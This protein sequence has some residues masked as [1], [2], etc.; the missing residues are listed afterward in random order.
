M[1]KRV[2]TKLKKKGI[3]LTILFAVF[4]TFVDQISKFLILIYVKDSPINII[5]DIFTF[6]YSENTGIA[7]SIPMPQVLLIIMNILLIFII[8]L[9]AIIDFRI[10][11]IH[12][13]IVIAA[14]I[15]G[16]MGNMV[17]RFQYGYVIDFISIWKYPIFNLADVFITVGILSLVVFYGKIKRSKI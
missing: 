9:L 10:E 4:F 17:D 3:L 8:V 5:S 1:P 11:K 2:I 13:Q 15:G 7:F 6:T 16:G 14:V 12:T